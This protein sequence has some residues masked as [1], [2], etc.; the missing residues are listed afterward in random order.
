MSSRLFFSK[1]L[2]GDEDTAC[3]S[4]HHPTLGG[5]DAMPLPIGVGAD[6]PPKA[7]RSYLRQLVAMRLL[8]VDVT[9]DRMPHEIAPSQRELARPRDPHTELLAV[10]DLGLEGPDTSRR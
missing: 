2:G 4:C 10:N 8:D 5:G 1:T 7:W 6:E 9:K 3:A